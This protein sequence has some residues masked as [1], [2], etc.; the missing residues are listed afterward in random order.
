MSQSREDTAQGSIVVIVLLIA[1][2]T[3]NPISVNIVVPALTSMAKG[4]NTDFA[5]AQLTL[6]AYLF[7]TAFSQ[8][9]LGPLSD[10]YGRRPVLLAG[11]VIYFLASVFCLMA[12]SIWVVVFGRILQGFGAASGF[13]LG[14]A[15]VRDLYEREKAASMLGY[16]TMGFSTAPMV[17]PLIGGLI[18]DSFGWRPI[19]LFTAVISL[20]LLFFV[21]LSLPE[22]RKPLQEGETRTGFVES[23]KILSRIPA[24]WA[25]ALNLSLS[26]ALFFTFLGGTPF[27]AID[28]FGMTGT[29]YGLY[30]AFV[31]VGFFIGNWFTAGLAQ[32]LGIWRMI[33]AGNLLGVIA[34]IAS[35]I[36]LGAG[37]HN[38][39]ALFAPMYLVG[40]SNG[41]AMANGMAGAVSVRPKLAG[42]A[43]G[44][45]GS[46]QMGLGAIATV[47]VGYLLT[48]TQSPMPVPI[49]MTV[50]AI[51]C[52][53]TG[54]WARTARS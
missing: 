51:L 5:T 8:L 41:L 30:F 49:C 47:V 9:I 48:L 20:V 27:I 7:A 37:W 19:F 38:H 23:F 10:R 25:Y 12:S 39:F 29:E 50:L 28:L 36:L 42:A 24:F 4:L 1:V 3:M 6:T 35:L 31:P 52:L 33:I 11:I 40:L 13:A 21:W 17:A 44:I 34:G 54:F 2:S 26:V 15:I 16:I 22:T 45:A 43:S 46:M 53:A 32:R 14:R 18:S